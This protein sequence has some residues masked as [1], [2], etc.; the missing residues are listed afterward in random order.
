MHEL[1]GYIRLMQREC[2]MP[3]QLPVNFRKVLIANRGEIACRILRTVQAYGI[4][5][6]AVYSAVD[7]EALHV[8]Q[9]DSAYYLG[10]AA[11]QESYLNIDRIINIAIE[12]GVDAIHPGYGF[13]AENAEFAQRCAQTGIIFIGPPADAIRLMGLKNAAKDEMRKANIPMVPGYHGTDQSPTTLLEEAKK[14]GFPILLKPAAG[15]GGKGMRI[16]TAAVEFEQALVSAKREAKSSFKDD[17]LIIEKYLPKARHIEVQIF[18]DHAGQ[19][20][21]LFERD[22]SLQRRH[23]KII[24]EAPAANLSVNVREHLYDC[25]IR[26]AKAIHY[27]GAGTI[28]FLVDDSEQY[29]FLEMNTRLQVEHPVT[30]MITGLDLVAWQL[31]IASGYPL[32]CTNAA[33]QK[34]GHAFEARIY[35]EDP[36]QDFLPASGKILYFSYPLRTEWLRMDTGIQTGDSV[37]AYYDPMLAKLIVHGK[38]RT[39]A[40]WR[41]QAALREIKLIGIKNNLAFLLQLIAHPFMQTDLTQQNKSSVHTLFIKE[42][43][44]ELLSVAQKDMRPI[45]AIAAVFINKNLS[46]FAHHFNAQQNLWQN[47]SGFRMN[48]AN[49]FHTVLQINQQ[50]YFVHLIN[51]ELA[52]SQTT[53]TLK[54][55]NE[56]FNLNL[57]QT[58]SEMTNP[59]Q[60]VYLEN[61]TLSL[62]A[63][64]YQAT[65]AL[66]KNR[67]FVIVG[68]D[69]VEVSNGQDKLKQQGVAQHG[70][71][72]APMTGTVVAVQT[73][74][75]AKVSR[76][77]PLVLIEA[78]KMEHAITAPFAGSVKNIY[79]NVGD[80]VTEGADVVELAIE[81]EGG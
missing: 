51:T 37:T 33:I 19:V 42:H 43:E 45:A 18:A 61:L 46:L 69:Y 40:L 2:S 9:A 1:E 55:D 30:E 21:H 54:I 29:Y 72:H 76:G 10:P 57:L 68:Q 71:L 48:A 53:Y 49:E 13:L 44:Q 3:Q 67:F 16:V 65:V 63:E 12:A 59:L 64:I 31:S 14:I 80:T 24:E 74:V 11:S 5:G 66:I 77:H 73:K 28:E 70:H 39:Q 20:V 15:G 35:A 56:Q 26:A 75:G 38:D 60:H 62:N 25:A 79:F 50:R 23:Q 81:D 17:Q 36:Q 52:T 32:P 22:C 27:V 58:N 47:C 7:K 6:V 34:T 4:H 8:K 78:M 41:L